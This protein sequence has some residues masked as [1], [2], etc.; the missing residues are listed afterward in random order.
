LF[1]CW[2]IDRKEKPYETMYVVPLRVQTK[3][4]R[5]KATESVFKLIRSNFHKLDKD[6]PRFVAVILT[7]VQ[8][9]VK[10]GVTQNLPYIKM[11]P[12]LS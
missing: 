2:W 11:Q 12:E 6:L 4:R 9:Y 5:I 1:I 3:S 8:D 10:F 7:Y